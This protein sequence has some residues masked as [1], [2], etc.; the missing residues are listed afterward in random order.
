MPSKTTGNKN[1]RPRKTRLTNQQQQ[2]L[3]IVLADNKEWH[4]LSMSARRLAERMNVTPRTV[5]KWRNDP[6]FTA[7]YYEALGKEIAD[8]IETADTRKIAAQKKRE[9]I[10]QTI[11]RTAILDAFIEK[12]WGGPMMS[13]IDGVTWL[14]TADD[15]RVHLEQHPECLPYE[16]VQ[17]QY[18]HVDKELAEAAKSVQRERK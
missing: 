15:Y 14:N 2:A 17:P 3:K 6:I 5:Y 18:E 12:N 13:P 7:A 9:R 10:D 4:W 1:G 16:L 11:H 8:K